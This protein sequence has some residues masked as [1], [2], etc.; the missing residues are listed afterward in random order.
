MSVLLSAIVCLCVSECVGLDVGLDRAYYVCVA[1]VLALFTTFFAVIS[2][3]T[4]TR[5]DTHT[6]TEIHKP[7]DRDTQGKKPNHR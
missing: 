4:H 5:K 3:H 7:R 2:N 6:H 1:T